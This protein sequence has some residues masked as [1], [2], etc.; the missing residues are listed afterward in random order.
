MININK[1]LKPKTYNKFFKEEF[2]SD[3]NFNSKVEEEIYLYISETTNKEMPLNNSR[4]FYQTILEEIDE[5]H[6]NL[7][8]LYNLIDKSYFKINEINLRK[9]T[10]NS[11]P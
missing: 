6:L 7:D 4:S 11:K 5:N 10:K 9:M 1:S 3:T 8:F 2:L